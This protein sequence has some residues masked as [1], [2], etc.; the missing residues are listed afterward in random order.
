MPLMWDRKK[1]KSQKHTFTKDKVCS[2][3]Q[4][5]NFLRKESYREKKKT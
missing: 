2:E 1:K 5:K 3:A 4:M